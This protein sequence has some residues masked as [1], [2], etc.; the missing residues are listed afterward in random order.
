MSENMFVA[1]LSLLDYI[2]MAIDRWVRGFL[3]D[4][5]EKLKLLATGQYQERRAAKN[6]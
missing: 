6:E 5:E 1:D 3:Y 4:H 2:E